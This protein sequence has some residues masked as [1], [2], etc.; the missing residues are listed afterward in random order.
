MGENHELV[1]G[2][3]V[4]VS[5]NSPRHNSLRDFL[6]TLLRPFV[7]GKAGKVSRIDLD[8]RVQRRV[9]GRKKLVDLAGNL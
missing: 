5:G 4:D 1:N 8:L 2:E 3:L 6:V 7:Q 9:L